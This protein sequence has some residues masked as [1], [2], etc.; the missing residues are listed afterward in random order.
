MEWNGEFAQFELTCVT[1]AVQS[2]LN[3]LV[4]VS[5]EL[6]SHCRGFINKSALPTYFYI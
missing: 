3:C 4:H 5:L 1:G 6:L 2:R